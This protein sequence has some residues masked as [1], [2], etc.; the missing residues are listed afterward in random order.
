MAFDEKLVRRTAE[1]LHRM[2]P[3]FRDVP[4]EAGWGGPINVS[5]LAMPFFG[6]AEPGNVHYGLG[7]T[8]NG[9]GPSHLG[10]KILAGLVTGT[11][12]PF[13]R[14]PV[15]T[16]EPKRFPPEPVRSPGMMV[17]N[18]AIVRKDDTEEGGGHA[19]PVTRTI[20]RLPRK[21]GFKLGPR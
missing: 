2:F 15:L 6:T 1:D 18:G 20:A 7:F 10:G 5:G 4:I 16:R 11:D 17:V 14:L 19:G 12:D 9:V 21:L 13:T 8:G 3:S